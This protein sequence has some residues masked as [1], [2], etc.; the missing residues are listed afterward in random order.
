MPTDDKPT[1]AELCEEIVKLIQRNV[2]LANLVRDIERWY[3]GGDVV[4]PHEMLAR[5]ADLRTPD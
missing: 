4:M 2:G 1:E 3:W 5:V